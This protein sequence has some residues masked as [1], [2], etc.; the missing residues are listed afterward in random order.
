MTNKIDKQQIFVLFSEK[1]PHGID[2]ARRSRKKHLPAAL[3]LAAD[4]GIYVSRVALNVFTGFE[5][6]EIFRI[7]RKNMMHAEVAVKSRAADR[8]ARFCHLIGES[9]KHSAG[10]ARADNGFVT[11]HR[12]KSLRYFL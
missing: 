2:L 1:Q 8:A 6:F 10:R 7:V 9:G 5:L 3:Q 4:G 12:K 11:V